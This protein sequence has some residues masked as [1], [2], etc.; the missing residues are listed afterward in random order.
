[1]TSTVAASPGT[2]IWR[3]IRKR[4]GRCGTKGIFERWFTLEERCPVCGYRFVR[5]DGAFTG[6]MFMNFVATLTLMIASLLAWVFWR[7]ITGRS[8][9]AFWPFAG[10][11]MLLAVFGPV[12]FYPLAA[13]TWAGVDLATRPLDPDE[14][15]DAD[16][17]RS[18]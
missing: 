12:L 2:I 17:H 14:I 4:C 1:M 7:G 13:S 11:A 8:D 16:A 9:L 18:P 3:G 6:V 15:A 5:E 10:A